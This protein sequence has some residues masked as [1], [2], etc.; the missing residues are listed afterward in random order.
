MAEGPWQGSG[1]IIIYSIFLL[2]DRMLFLAEAN[3]AKNGKEDCREVQ[4]RQSS[5]YSLGDKDR[6]FVY[7][8][9]VRSFRFS[10]AAS[11]LILPFS[12]LC[13]T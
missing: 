7:R 10:G 3:L 8:Q 6:L 2:V 12:F 1:G 13:G 11:F 4:G 5:Q 9:S